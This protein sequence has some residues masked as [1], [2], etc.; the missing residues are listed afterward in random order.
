MEK[1]F[2]DLQALKT[3]TWE[4]DDD[5][6]LDEFL[7][8]VDTESEACY[9]KVNEAWSNN[10][11]IFEKFMTLLAPTKPHT[12]RQTQATAPS[13]TSG[14][15]KPNADLK[16]T[17]LIK[18]CTLTEFNKFTDT[19]STYIRSSCKQI[20]A[21]AL[22]GQLNVNMESYLFTELK[23]KGFSRQSNLTSFLKYMDEF[24]LIK[25]PLHQ[26]RMVI[27]ASKEN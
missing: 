16:P 3:E 19:F 22:W 5:E 8:R 18:D 6:G 15:F 17:F 12:L 13:I 4:E 23:D 7:T 21:E 26:R 2:A 27:F 11:E 24:A 20:P 14:G 25:F 9:N 10:Q 1:G